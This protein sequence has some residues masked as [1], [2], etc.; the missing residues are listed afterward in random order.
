MWRP[1][2]YDTPI[3]EYWNTIERAG[4]WDVG[5]QRIVEISGPDV[6]T[7]MNLLTTRDASRVR[8][9]QCRYVFLTNQ[10]GGQ[11]AGKVTSA[12]YS[13]RPEQNIGFI[14]AG[15]AWAENGTR[16]EVETPE[17]TCALEVTDLPFLDKAKS[18]PRRSLRG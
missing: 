4:I 9:G 8:I 13:P 15:L 2:S 5:V 18:I 17:G 1:V 16:L 11:F 10:Y 12:V 6:E 14:L 7:Y 3:N